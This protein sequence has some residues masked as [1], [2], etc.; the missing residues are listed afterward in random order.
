LEYDFLD[1]D[2]FEQR[3]IMSVPFS[4]IS[5]REGLNGLPTHLTSTTF[6]D[7]QRVLAWK[8]RRRSGYGID[9][10]KAI[11]AFTGTMS[12]MHRTLSNAVEYIDIKNSYSQGLDWLKAQ[13]PASAK[14]VDV[15][16]A[17][18]QMMHCTIWTESVREIV[19]AETPT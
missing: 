2:V 10:S 12:G 7:S 11:K 18:Y 5:T 13:Y 17:G 3:L 14:R 9:R 19:S 8:R 16:D 4:D 6:P 1:V 15:R